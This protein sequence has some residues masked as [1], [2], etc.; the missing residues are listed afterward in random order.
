MSGLLKENLCVEKYQSENTI[1]SLREEC[2]VKV[3]RSKNNS[4]PYSRFSYRNLRQRW[5]TECYD[6]CVGGHML[7]QTSLHRGVLE[8]GYVYAWQHRGT[9][10]FY[11]QHSI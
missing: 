6:C 3:S 2:Y 7:F 5:K 9:R 11:N 4:L 10:S 1:S 8:E